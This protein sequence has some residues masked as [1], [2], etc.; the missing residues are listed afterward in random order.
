MLARVGPQAPDVELRPDES[1]TNALGQDLIEL[2]NEVED[3]LPIGCAQRLDADT[4]ASG[5]AWGGQL[6]GAAS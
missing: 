2:D 1:V 6:A 5:P 3:C 4:A